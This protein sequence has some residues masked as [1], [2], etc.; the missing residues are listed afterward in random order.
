MNERRYQSWIDSLRCLVPNGEHGRLAIHLRDAG[1]WPATLPDESARARMTNSLAREGKGEE[2]KIREVF[3]LMRHTGRYDPLY[4]LCDRL[5]LSRPQ[6]LAP[7]ALINGAVERIKDVADRAQAM[8]VEAEQLMQL[9]RARVAPPVS[10]KFSLPEDDP[11]PTC[12][13]SESQRLEGGF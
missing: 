3:E 8:L 4:Y 1:Y 6:P 7:D 2:L 11:L 9:S 5:G 12:W 13:M 10:S